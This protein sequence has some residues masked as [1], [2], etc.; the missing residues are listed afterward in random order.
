MT[1]IKLLTICAICMASIQP[2]MSLALDT[3]LAQNAIDD[4]VALLE[5]Q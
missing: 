3:T 2:N 1:K 5:A 4:G